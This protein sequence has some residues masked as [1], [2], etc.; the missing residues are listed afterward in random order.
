MFGLGRLH[1]IREEDKVLF[2]LSGHPAPILGTFEWVELVHSRASTL[3]W[4]PLRY[5]AST[6][7][8]EDRKGMSLVYCWTL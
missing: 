5:L 7:M 4:V 2:L 1:V 8:M 3:S 6:K